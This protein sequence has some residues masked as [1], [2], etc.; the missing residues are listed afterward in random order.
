VSAQV[1]RQRLRLG[2]DSPKLMAIYRED[3]LTLDQL[4]AFAVSEDH[5]RQD[6]VF[7]QLAHNRQPYAIRRAMTE[8]KVPA[9]DRRAVF[10]GIEA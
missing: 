8:A 6:Q 5:E 4:M 1:V 9:D 3:G 7:E 10:I 2:A